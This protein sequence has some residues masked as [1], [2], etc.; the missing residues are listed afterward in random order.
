MLAAAAALGLLGLFAD[1]AHARSPRA[2]QPGGPR[3]TEIARH[4]RRS[5]TRARRRECGHSARYRREA[6]RRRKGAKTRPRTQTHPDEALSAFAPSA[7]GHA[8]SGP[9]PSGEACANTE[10]IPSGANVAQVRE[11]TLC[12]I[13]QQRADH[14]EQALAQSAKLTQAAQGHSEDM[15]A[16]DY[17]EHTSPSGEE[18][19]GWIIAS[20]YVPHGA[21]YELGENIDVGTLSLATPAATVTAWMNSQEHRANILNSEFRETGIGVAAAAP[22]YFS[23]GEPGATYT[24]DVGVL[25]D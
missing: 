1:Q 22:A 8:Q 13:N 17:F 21:A 7:P 25:A 10:L 9:L 11:A 23:E 6:S 20:G 15:V 5:R 18:F 24:Q 19:Q 3:R 12:L 14:G 2:G 4:C 16:R